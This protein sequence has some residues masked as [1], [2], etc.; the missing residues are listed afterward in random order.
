MEANVTVVRHAL[1]RTELSVL[2]DRTT[3]TKEFRRALHNLSLLMAC[4]ATRDLPTT[5][6]PIETPLAFCVGDGLGTQVVVVPILRAGLGMAQAFLEFLPTAS[7]G[8]VGLARDEKTLLPSHYY[9]K[10]P[11][12]LAEAEVILVD[13]MLATGNSA[14][15][16]ADELKVRGARSIRLVCILGCR[17]G[18]ASV[19][20]RH[21][22][23]SIFLAAVDTSLDSHG[24]I[25]PGLG[26]AGDRYFGT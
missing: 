1:A 12:S 26:D 15:D 9:F 19:H 24:Y 17:Q 23:I 2:R 18:I 10:A 20:A 21:P 3:T 14:A 16:A 5:E 4:E 8:H 11:S 6:C 25:V 13:P 22:D 7:V